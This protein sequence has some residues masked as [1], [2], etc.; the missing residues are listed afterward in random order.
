MD[1]TQS[2]NHGEPELSIG[3]T[4]KPG[5]DGSPVSID[6]FQYLRHSYQ[7]IPLGLILTIGCSVLTALLIWHHVPQYITIPWLSIFVITSGLYILIIN[8]FNKTKSHV[9]IS[10]NWSVYNTFLSAIVAMAWGIGSLLFYPHLTYETQLSLLVIIAL[11]VTAYIPV[12]SSVISGY[13]I[14]ITALATPLLSGILILPVDSKMI[15]LLVILLAYILLTLCA[16]SFNHSLLSSFNLALEIDNRMKDLHESNE[17]TKVENI[18]LKKQLLD[19]Q[20]KHKEMNLAREQA[21]ITVQSIGEGIITTDTGGY[22]TYINPIAEMYTGWQSE[23]ACGEI[24]SNV[25]LMAD[26]SNKEKIIN[27]VSQCLNSKEPIPNNHHALLTRKDKHEY[28]IEYSTTPIFN[29]NKQISGAVLVFRDIT[30]EHN[31]VEDLSWQ[32]C[33]DALT[34]LINSREFENRLIKILGNTSPSN[35]QHALCYIDIDHFKI[36]N[37]SCGHPGGDNLLKKI[38]TA[39][40]NKARETDTVARLDGDKF[41]VILYSCDIKKAMLIAELFREQVEKMD[42]TWNGKHFKTTASIGV[43]PVTRNTADITGLLQLADMACRTAKDAGGNQIHVYDDNNDYKSS[44]DNDEIH[45]AEEIQNALELEGFVL[46]MQKIIPLDA[47][48]GVSLCEILLRMKQTESQL[49]S[50]GQ[51]LNAAQRYHLMEKLDKWTVNACFELISHNHQVLDK[52]DIININISSQSISDNRFI[53]YINTLIQSYEIDTSRICFEIEEVCLLDTAHAVERF[54]STMKKRGFHF[55]LDNFNSGLNLLNR[56]N[57]LGL[58]YIKID[59]CIS[60]KPKERNIDATAIESMNRI[61]HLMGL[62]TIAKYVSDDKNLK[63][64]REIGVDYAQGFAI[65]KPEP[66]VSDN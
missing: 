20:E 4:L 58:D 55:A 29:H 13:V 16:V 45:W 65:S 61:C 6:Q 18:Q 27:P 53:N 41:G 66:L 64:L 33:H 23:Q 8:E 48:D 56:I 21:E 57:K 25:F 19:R 62:K 51:F 36:I 26:E 30:D 2:V 12:L 54:I 11:Y 46:Y 3:K 60:D 52:I 43:I 31:P 47:D 9:G 50:P 15:A 7:Q 5:G 37:E 34:G 42:F 38:A 35:R 32:A 17:K 40:R 44:E 49:V 59:G 24:I 63:T 14:F 22:I 39:L 28:S 1:K 10:K